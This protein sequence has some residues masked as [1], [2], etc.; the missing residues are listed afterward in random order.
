MMYDKR[1]AAPPLG[2]LSVAIS[3]GL[4]KGPVMR[5]VGVAIE[6][7]RGCGRKLISGVARYNQGT[8]HLGSC[9]W[10]ICFEPHG[11][12]DQ[13]PGW[14]KDWKGDGLLVQIRNEKVAELVQ[15]LNVPTVD[16]RGGA[17]PVPGVAAV[18]VD[19]DAV[20]HLAVE[21]LYERGFRN[22]AFCELDIDDDCRLD[23][24]REAF[25]RQATKA[26]FPCQL[27]RL[28]AGRRKGNMFER[29]KGQVA[30]W[31]ASVQKPVGVM[32]SDHP[33]GLHFLDACRHCG[34]AVPEDV[35]VLGSGNDDFVCSLSVPEQTSVDVGSDRIGYEAAALLERLM[36]GDPV[37]KKPLLLPPRRVINRGSTDVL[38]TTDREVAA[39]V[40]FIRE[41]ACRPITV[42]EVLK[43]V[44][45][46]RGVLEPRLREVVGRTI[47]Q[48]IRNTQ[49]NRVK[50]LLAETDWPIKRIAVTA[51]FHSSQYLTRVFHKTVG[52]P[53]A[54]YRVNVRQ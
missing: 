35:A 25:V 8:T 24:K 44:A 18:G 46:S 16:L 13:P 31:L 1:R 48:E 38:A 3:T 51:G 23:Y 53:P 32:M 39:A 21:H 6:T 27:L 36:R 11:G 7:A 43:K 17:L 33:L 34:V 14:L 20:S 37:P 19:F 50:Q 49:L 29:I 4:S 40:R 30:K 9:P 10:S 54:E 28:R 52:T 41:N 15:R 42:S 22:F 2:W 5:H 47:H 45:L 26:G 12:R